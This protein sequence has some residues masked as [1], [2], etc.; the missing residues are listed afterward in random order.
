MRLILSEES[1][2]V[3]SARSRRAS[4][5]VQRPRFNL[6]PSITRRGSMNTVPMPKVWRGYRLSDAIASSAVSLSAFNTSK[7]NSTRP[8]PP[9]VNGLEM[10]R[11]SKA[12]DD[13]RREPRV[14]S[15]MR[16]GP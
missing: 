10:R 16:C 8:G 7:N 9:I 3:K 5:G 14:S 15:M 2:P 12:C 1:Q 11:S 13:R 6:T 4:S